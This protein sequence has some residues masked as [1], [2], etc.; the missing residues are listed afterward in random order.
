MNSVPCRL[1]ALSV[2]LLC[3]LAARPLLAQATNISGTW[4]VTVTTR[5]ATGMSKLTLVQSGDK[6][7]GQYES[8]Y[9]KADLSGTVKGKAF[10]FTFTMNLEG[11]PQKFIYDGTAE[12]DQLRGKVS[13]PGVVDGT[14]VARR[15]E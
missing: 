7:T 3:A 6:V 13:L 1:I 8:S 14:F 12:K 15:E 5:H 9:G 10:N 11:N 4:N 2:V